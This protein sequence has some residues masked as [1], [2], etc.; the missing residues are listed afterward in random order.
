MTASYWWRKCKDFATAW[1]FSHVTAVLATH[2]TTVKSNRLYKHWNSSWRRRTCLSPI[3]LTGQLPCLPLKLVQPNSPSVGMSILDSLLS[4]NLSFPNSPVLCGS[5][6]RREGKAT[7]EGILR[8][9]PWCSAVARLQFRWS[10]LDKD[11][12]WQRL[13]NTRPCEGVMCFS[14]YVTETPGGQ[15]RRNRR[16]MKF[17]ST[18]SQSQQTPDSDSPTG[19][20]ESTSRVIDHPS[21]QVVLLQ[22]RQFTLN[23]LILCTVLR[24]TAQSSIAVVAK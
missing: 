2:R 22:T 9:T 16:H 14:S 1:G 20:G 19:S 18:G 15:F 8:Q 13:D 7:A 10:S 17:I 3:S 11:R 12:C 5:W 24:R 6:P 23:H 4:K 21:I